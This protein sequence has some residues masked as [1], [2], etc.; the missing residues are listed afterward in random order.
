MGTMLEGV[1]WSQETKDGD[2]A[3]YEKEQEDYCA[4]VGLL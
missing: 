3:S 4:G 1:G 2:A